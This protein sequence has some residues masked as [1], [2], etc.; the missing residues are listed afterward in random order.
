MFL[1]MPSPRRRTYR[2]SRRVVSSRYGFLQAPSFYTPGVFGLQSHTT[3]NRI[4]RAEE[5]VLGVSFNTQSQVPD[6]PDVSLHTTYS[7]YTTSF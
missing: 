7:R 5:A 2:V 1:S 4:V 3:S 6:I